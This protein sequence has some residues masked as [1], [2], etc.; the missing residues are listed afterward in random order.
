[1]KDR[2]AAQGD[3]ENVPIGKVEDGGLMDDGRM[4]VQVEDENAQVGKVEEEGLKADDGNSQV[5]T[6]DDGSSK[7]EKVSCW[8]CYR[9]SR[10][11]MKGLAVV[12][13]VE[14]GCD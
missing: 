5:G 3:E 10:K 7:V 9:W 11:W 2:L 1:M 8:N 14:G 6:G 4:A 12:G 13:C